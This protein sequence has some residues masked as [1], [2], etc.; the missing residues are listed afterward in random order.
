MDKYEVLNFLIENE[1]YDDAFEFVHQ[2]FE[3]DSLEFR[4]Y[5]G[6]VKSFA[7]NLQEGIQALQQLK[8]D[9]KGTEFESI[10]AGELAAALKLSGV[11][12]LAEKEIHS[13]LLLDPDSIE[14]QEIAL[15]IIK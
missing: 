10:I 8:K 3:R 1:F 2:V 12:V 15:D 4:Y 7:G 9:T 6:F 13:A 14:L 11:Q 5:L